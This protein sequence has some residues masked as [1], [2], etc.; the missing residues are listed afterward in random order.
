MNAGLGLNHNELCGISLLSTRK[1]SL[2]HVRLLLTFLQWKVGSKWGGS[3]P[4]MQCYG[5]RMMRW[6]A[7]VTTLIK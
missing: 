2:R 6:C 4:I 1:L 7:K 3:L 5:F